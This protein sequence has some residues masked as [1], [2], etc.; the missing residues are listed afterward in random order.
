[1]NSPYIEHDPL[2][3]GNISPRTA[4]TRRNSKDI[5]RE[6]PLEIERIKYAVTSEDISL[7]II[8]AGTR[9]HL[10]NIGS[11]SISKEY[12][13]ATGPISVLV[14]EGHGPMFSLLK[15]TIYPPKQD[16]SNTSDPTMQK[17]GKGLSKFWD[18]TKDVF[19]QMPGIKGFSSEGDKMQYVINVLSQQFPDADAILMAHSTI[20]IALYFLNQGDDPN[21]QSLK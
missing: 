20:E 9:C 5:Y 16:V 4:S 14:R 15:Q 7:R 2:G 6:Y 8:P 11:S 3:Y 13:I 1:M 21:L 18:E 12:F 19:R 17:I 10:W